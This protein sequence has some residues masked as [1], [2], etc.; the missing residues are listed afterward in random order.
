[1]CYSDFF[2]FSNFEK[3]KKRKKKKKRQTQY[4]P[5]DQKKN[6][7]FL[8]HLPRRFSHELLPAF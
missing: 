5:F 7:S 3:K 4:V 8:Q 6:L 2:P 1:M